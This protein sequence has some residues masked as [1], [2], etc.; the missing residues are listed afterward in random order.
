MD[1]TPYTHTQRSG[2]FVIQSRE[3][4]II[5]STAAVKCRCSQRYH[6]GRPTDGLPT[7]ARDGSSG[8]YRRIWRRVAALVIFT[9]QIGFLC[10]CRYFGR[11]RRNDTAERI[12][13]VRSVIATARTG[14]TRNLSS[15]MFLRQNPSRDFPSYL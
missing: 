4:H 2:D 11:E 12:A 10:E 5:H 13:E 14:P 15:N 9:G 6:T 8:E 7:R 3:D 1:T